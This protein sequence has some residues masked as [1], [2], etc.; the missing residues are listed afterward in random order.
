MKLMTKPGYWEEEWG[1]IYIFYIYCWVLNV[2]NSLHSWL[3]QHKNGEFS[4]S[5]VVLLKG[6]QKKTILGSYLE[7]VWDQ[8]VV[9]V[10]LLLVELLQI[11]CILSL[12]I[13]CHLMPH[14][15]LL[16]GLE[17]RAMKRRG[18]SHTDPSNIHQHRRQWH[19]NTWNHSNDRWWKPVPA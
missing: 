18:F 7:D 19:L 16:P 11:W 9:M 14:L 13:R 6:Q 1:T 2:Y 3:R 5:V 15:G 8:G 17:N 12:A 4:F 10:I